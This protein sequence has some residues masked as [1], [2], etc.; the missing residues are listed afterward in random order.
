MVFGGRDFPSRVC[1]FPEDFSSPHNPEEIRGAKERLEADMGRP[2]SEVLD[3]PRLTAIFDMA[4][5]RSAPSF[6]KC[7]REIHLLI[8]RLRAD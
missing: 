2:Y 1:G 5:A 7:W 6:D 3:Q 4:A 8:E